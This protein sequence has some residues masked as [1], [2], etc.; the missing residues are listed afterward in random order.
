MI[1]AL[2]NALLA[3]P[4]LVLALAIVTLLGASGLSVAL[5]TGLAL[6]AQYARVTRSALLVVRNMPY[7]DAAIAMGAPAGQVI[8]RHMLP[9][10]MPTLLAFAGVTFG[11]G[12]L[13]AAALSFLGLS[14]DLGV[15]DWG[16]MLFEGRV[17]FRSAPWIS[18]APGVAIS[19]IVYAAN[20]LADRV[21]SAP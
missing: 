21:S 3:I 19:L 2:L 1:S 6:V 4:G 15:P 18:L 11:Y 13:N 9:N 5:A 7:V 14:G 8:V 16:T 17:T 10:V 12:V 20:R